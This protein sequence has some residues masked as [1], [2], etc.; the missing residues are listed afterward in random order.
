[1]PLFI[2]A[3]LALSSCHGGELKR[4]TG[5]QC[6]DDTDC[7][8]P[9]VCRFGRCRSECTVD[10]DCPAGSVCVAVPDGDGYRVCTVAAEESCPDVACPDGLWCGPDGTCREGCDESHPCD[11]G[12]ICVEGVCM[13]T[14]MADGDADGDGD[15]ESDA[16]FDGDNDDA[17]IDEC[18]ATGPEI[19]CDGLDND[20]DSATA[21]ECDGDS[22][23][24]LCSDDCDDAASSCTDDC[25]IDE[26][27][28][29]IA[30]CRD[31]CFDADGDDHGVD[32]SEAVVGSGAVAVGNCTSDGATTCFFGDE[33]CLGEDC[34][35]G[36][37]TRAS[38]HEEIPCDEIDNDCDEATGDNPDSDGDGYFACEDDCDD[39]NELSFPGAPERCDGE[40]NDC[41]EVLPEVELDAD[42]D[43]FMPCN[44]DCDDADPDRYPGNPEVLCDEI[45]ND[46]DPATRDDPNEDEDEYSVCA[47]DCADDD[48]YS[49]PDA[50]EVC[51]G[52]D[53]DCDGTID[54]DCLPC[55][56]Y[57]PTELR[58]IDLAITLSGDGD[59]V[60]VRPGEYEESISFYGKAISLV[61]LGG[62]A[63]TTLRSISPTTTVTIG[64]SETGEVLLEGFTI[65]GGGSR[66]MVISA[67]SPLLRD[68]NITGNGGVNRGVGA[69][70]VSSSAPTLHDVRIDGNRSG[71]IGD[72]GV[73]VYLHGSTFT[74]TGGSISRNR[75]SDWAS[76]GGGMFVESST[77]DLVNVVIE[78]NRSWRGGGLYVGTGAEVT[79]TNVA[80]D[81]NTGRF[82]GGIYFDSGDGSLDMTNVMVSG[83]TGS[84]GG[85][86]LLLEDLGTITMNNVAIV[87]NQSPGAGGGV[88]MNAVVATMTN[89][90][91]AGNSSE[92]DGGGL[93]VYSRV[94]FELAATNCIIW[95]NRAARGGGVFGDGSN[96]PVFS[97]SFI[98]ENTPN[99]FQNL[100]ATP[101]GRRGSWS[102]PP[103]FLDTT[104]EN[105]LLWDLH[106]TDE[107]LV[108]GEDFGG[109]PDIENPDGSPSHPGSYGGEHAGD[110][111]LD[112]DGYAEWWHTGPYV[113]VTD[114][115]ADWDCDDQDPDVYPFHG[116]P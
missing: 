85:G 106:L 7:Q 46:C 111:D 100:A 88:Y 22:D 44:E 89:V 48:E 68:L 84:Q 98:H 113:P 1:M 67:A 112:A 19:C 72:A 80:I 6:V 29:E 74:M 49:H 31:L 78:N 27:G 37:A 34:D 41:D 11:D 38:G 71:A 30:D 28:D 82:G 96:D 69:Y 60:C 25:T 105:P 101:F 64:R 21:D 116:C 56:V 86:G 10:R 115:S 26:D 75:D 63:G 47:G 16:E 55:D 51:D 4:A 32:A 61:G 103:G 18:I 2:A 70:I 59:T 92:S 3:I 54:D 52:E 20:C 62:S 57:V 66:G 8:S 76:N 24:V 42:E 91:I 39:D 77:V 40:D 12:R 109:D 99:D 73:G 93:F 5:A 114:S 14:P 81:R 15:V 35:D 90:T 9:L 79:L 108:L 58:T 95:N 110:W 87:G 97:Y 94:G 33:A 102:L 53:T 50:R 23:G 17:D 43:G 36:D 107:S 83:N 13:E 104:D 65:T 45:D